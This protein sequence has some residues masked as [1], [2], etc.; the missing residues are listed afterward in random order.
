MSDQENCEA[1]G[2]IPT[3]VVRT[4]LPSIAISRNNVYALPLSFALNKQHVIDYKCQQRNSVAEYNSEYENK[5]NTKAGLI[6]T[7]DPLTRAYQALTSAVIPGDLSA[8]RRPGRSTLW[9]AITP[10]GTFG[11]P[12]PLAR[13]AAAIVDKPE[14][15]FR[16]PEGFQFGGRF[17]DKYYSTCGKKLFELAISLLSGGQTLAELIS[18]TIPRG[19]SVQ[20]RRLRSDATVGQVSMVRKPEINI[21]KV[22]SGN[23]AAFKNAIR[24]V[25]DEMT[26]YA[27]PVTRLVRRDGVVLNPLV[28]AKVLRTVPDNRDMEGASYVL[29]ASKPTQIG[30]DE[31]GVLS[32][33]GIVSVVYVLPNGG[34]LAIRKTRNLSNGERR[35]LGRLVAEAEKMPV[36][37]D[38]AARIEYIAAEMDGPI[39]YEQ[40]FG[41][42]KGPNDMV[43][44]MDPKT[45]REKQV[46]RWYRD[47][48]LM[49]SGLR[50]VSERET[51]IEDEA[52]L[53]DDL[54]TAISLVNRGGQIGNITPELR[55]PAIEMSKFA[56]SKRINRRMTS[57]TVGRD[58]L[59][60]VNSSDANEHLGVMFA[61]EMQS[62][63]GAL[64]P[65]VWF[66]G[67]GS[68][69]PYI[70]S[71][72]EDV[73]SVSRVARST[74]MD[75]A[76]PE[77]M[78][79]LMIADV[80]T[81]VRNRNPSGIYTIGDGPA[82]R[83]FASPIPSAA[84]VE[85][86]RMTRAEILS[87]LDQS[88]YRSYFMRLRKEQRK[89]AIA[90]IEELLYRA[91]QFN[92]REFARRMSIDGKL[93][94]SE[95]RHADILRRIFESRIGVLSSSL[96]FLKD[97][98]NGK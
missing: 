84:S 70:V 86:E 51:Q 69:R 56:D 10:G 40:S 93:T 88:M 22:G 8:V 49:D 20:G 21:P 62:Q 15:G 59:V 54:K 39:A 71:Y 33:S 68:R 95:R 43:T 46:R 81:D 36:T 61:S 25:T 57:Y 27:E 13:A 16:C 78:L 11:T 75:L 79:R 76:D 44:V 35:R 85:S 34:T 14:R 6:G 18:P 52:G 82:R 23:F 5:L 65:S 48:F 4:I 12:N 72:P 42:L 3:K 55:I 37:D 7:G 19:I 63:L 41:D 32:N 9:S 89:R 83:T 28:S 74:G 92:F 66:A 60:A 77:D 91:K 31:L 47:A 50:Q 38:P 24:N 29:Y 2:K 73:D 26:Q 90:L 94:E 53:V 58:K 80:L 64:A 45:K 96:K 17:T 30:K 67:S 98:V 1:C 97:V 87:M